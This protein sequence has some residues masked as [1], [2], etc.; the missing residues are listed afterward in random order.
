VKPGSRSLLVA[1]T[2]AALAW[3]AAARADRV[4]LYP[5]SGRV[6]E[7]RRGEIEDRVAGVIRALGHEVLSPPGG[8]TSTDRPPETAAQM[9]GLATAAGA[10]YVVVA[11]VEPMPAQYRLHVR[12]GYQPTERVEELVVHVMLAEEEARLRDV[13]GSMLRERGLGEDAM[14]LTGSEEDLSPEERARREEEE[15]ARLAAEEAERQRLA[16]EARQREEEERRRQEEEARRA[17]EER[18]QRERSAWGSRPLYGSDGAWMVALGGNGGY[19]GSF[20]PRTIMVP[21]GMGGTTTRQVGAGGP[22]GMIQVRVGRT[23]PGVDGLE[24][25]GGL[26]VVLGAIGGIDLVVGASWQWTPS[27]APIHV[28]PVL[29]L[30]ALFTFTGAQNVGFV[31]R[32]GAIASWAPTR[33][34]QLELALPELGVL[35]N[36]AWTIGATLRAGYRFD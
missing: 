33:Q 8:V 11:E 26:D 34:L 17:E 31:V 35:S 12:V 23:I 27:T 4:V 9:G 13:L 15:R 5:L 24:L 1:F 22:L 19:L 36:G 29:E 10:T 32:G 6:D 14:R 3:P 18:L 7:E 28:G 21:D 2:I 16:E 30:G 25:R 20:S